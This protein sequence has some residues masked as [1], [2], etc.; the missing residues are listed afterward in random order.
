MV[1]EDGPSEAGL[2][3]GAQGPEDLDGDEPHASVGGWEELHE[4]AERGG[5]AAEAE[6][7]EASG[8]E[9]EAEGGAHGGEESG[10]EGEEG[11]AEE[12]D[13]SA[14]RVSD[15][16]PRGRAEE[17]ADEDD[18][19]EAALLGGV[20]APLAAHGRTEE[21]QEHHLHRVTHPRQSREEEHHQLEP[22]EPGAVDRLVHGPPRSVVACVVIL[23][24][25]DRHPRVRRR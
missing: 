7:D 16:A 5:D 8:E 14:S 21:G 10:E 25:G 15:E 1:R 19:G 2:D 6:A 20:D 23:R 22:T 12:G 9:K 17:H 4:E 18:G 24:L 3:D 13:A 11:G